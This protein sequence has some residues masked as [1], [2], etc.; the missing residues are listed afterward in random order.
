ME[1]I[2]V[3]NPAIRKALTIGEAFWRG[4]RKQGLVSRNLTSFGKAL[5]KHGHFDFKQGGKGRWIK[6]DVWENKG[7]YFSPG[8]SFIASW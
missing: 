5:K 1:A 2:A 4:E 3:E 6:P 7:Y 8:F